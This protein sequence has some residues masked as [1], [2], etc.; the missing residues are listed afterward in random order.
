MIL[1]DNRI[2]KDEYYLNIAKEVSMRGTCLRRCYGAVIVKDDTIISTGY[3]GAPRGFVNCNQ[4]GKCIR[5]EQGIPPGQRYELCRS[6]H[7]EMNA[8]I[9]ASK[10]D[11]KDAT[12]Y[13][14]GRLSGDDKPLEETTCCS[15]CIRNIV[16]SGIKTVITY[17]NGNIDKFEVS[18][19]VEQD[20]SFR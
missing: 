1:S 4:I 20:W 12:L 10:N 5:Q 2:S 8:I 11:M 19:W 14:F 3:T 15:M 9:N 6:V 18:K 17:K 7:A 16:N 13:V